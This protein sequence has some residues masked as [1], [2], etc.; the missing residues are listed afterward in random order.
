M[1]LRTSAA[2]LDEPNRRTDTTIHCELTVPANAQ[3]Y[4]AGP[5]P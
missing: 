5:F 2:I 3:H 4:L 1:T